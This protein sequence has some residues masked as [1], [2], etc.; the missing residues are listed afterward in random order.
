MAFVSDAATRLSE[1]RYTYPDVVVTCEGSGVASRTMTE[2]ANPCVVME[3]LSESTEHYDRTQKFEYYRA[4]DSLL[5]YVLVNTDRQLV[6]V[7]RRDP[8]GHWGL[9]SM[10][11][12]ADSV[13]LA[14]L[15]AAFPVTSLYERTD[16]PET[17][18]AKSPG[19]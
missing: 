1:S 18:P 17:L 8:E 10:H 19:H 5:E 15:G 7:Y 9:F 12:P 13:R 6:E 2:I 11:G 14:A 4:C 16:V 3:V